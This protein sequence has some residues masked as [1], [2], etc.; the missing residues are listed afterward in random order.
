ML[1]VHQVSTSPNQGTTTV[2]KSSNMI[3]PSLDALKIR[4]DGI[5]NLQHGPKVAFIWLARNSL[6]S[7]Q[8]QLTRNSFSWHPHGSTKVVCC[9]AA[10]LRYLTAPPQ[11]NQHRLE[12]VQHFIHNGLEMTELSMAVT[13]PLGLMVQIEPQARAS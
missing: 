3:Q 2:F 13:W 5:K 6:S 9:Y 1:T 12:I 10:A 4:H 8:I 7:S 11:L